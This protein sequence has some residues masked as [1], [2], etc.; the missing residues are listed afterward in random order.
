[1]TKKWLISCALISACIGLLSVSALAAQPVPQRGPARFRLFP[2]LSQLS[3]NVQPMSLETNL[4]RY[5]PGSQPIPRAKA[6][7][8]QSGTKLG[9]LFISDRG[10]TLNLF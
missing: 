3:M 7:R 5:A 1:M 10:L 4:P 9:S 2:E 6:D 8:D